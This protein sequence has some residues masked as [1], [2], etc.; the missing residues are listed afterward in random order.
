MQFAS[1]LSSDTVGWVVA[2]G[3]VDF[4]VLEF[5]SGRFSLL[6]SP[7]SNAVFTRDTFM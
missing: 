1:E 5:D 4:G 3:T 7:F 6:F 2:R